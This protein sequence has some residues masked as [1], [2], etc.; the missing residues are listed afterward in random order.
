MPGV[1][2][3][4]YIRVVWIVCYQMLAVMSSRRYLTTTRRTRYKCSHWYDNVLLCATDD[5]YRS[6]MRIHH[7]TFDH[8]LS[9]LR[10]HAGQVFTSC[11]GV[12]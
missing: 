6:Y 10:C 8:V 1:P 4:N 2:Q 12:S 9:L 7:S 11:R 3:E 5:L